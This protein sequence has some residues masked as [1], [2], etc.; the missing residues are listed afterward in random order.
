MD[1]EAQE[2]RFYEKE[3]F[4]EL[5]ESIIIFEKEKPDEALTKDYGVI[6]QEKKRIFDRNARNV[7][8]SNE[9]TRIICERAEQLRRDA[10]P[11]VDIKDIKWTH[12]REKYEKIAEEELKQRKL[13]IIIR[14]YDHNSKFEDWN[15]SELAY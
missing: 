3:G 1:A 13:K 2:E 4:V 15:I 12:S 14:R 9:M 10:P 5:E 11:K 8:H 6:N 7:L